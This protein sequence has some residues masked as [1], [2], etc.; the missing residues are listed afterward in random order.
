L[1]EATE[2]TERGLCVRV[3]PPLTG[4]KGRSWDVILAEMQ[5]YP[6]PR[7]LLKIGQRFASPWRGSVVEI[8]V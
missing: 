4:A 3:A 2:V 5:A 6:G 1:E 7:G 8:C